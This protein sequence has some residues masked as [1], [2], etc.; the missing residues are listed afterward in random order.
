MIDEFRHTMNLWGTCTILISDEDGSVTVNAPPEVVDAKV[1]DK[2]K[3]ETEEEIR[4]RSRK[5]PSDGKC[6]VCQEVK[7][8]N[9]HHICYACW[10]SD[11]LRRDGWKDGQPH[12]ESCHCE[13][14]GQHQNKDGSDKGS[15]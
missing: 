9:R 5:P 7:P 10:V 6:K 2:E 14:L 13:G 4:K 15:N 8:L 12:P 3:E 1:P 11:N